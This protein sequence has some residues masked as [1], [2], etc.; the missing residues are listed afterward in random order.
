M[1][2]LADHGLT[3]ISRSSAMQYRK[4][5]KPLRQIARELGVQGA[6]EGTVRRAGD[7]V[8][9]SAQLVDARSERPL[10]GR[11]YQRD[12]ADVL[13]MQ[14][15]VALTIVGQ[16]RLSLT[17]DVKARL[18]TPR[19]INPEAH[20]AYL[21]GRSNVSQYTRESF[22]RALEYFQRAIEIDPTYAEAYAGLS[23]T[24][25]SLSSAWL[26]AAEAMP[27]ARAAAAKALELDPQL[28]SA[29]ASLATVEAFYDWQWG[30]AEREFSRA[31]EL[32]PSEPTAHQN[33]G[34]L[35]V[36]HRR[37]EEA[38]RELQRAHE[39]DPLSPFISFYGLFPANL[40]RNYA[41]AIA[42]G[43]KVAAEYPTFSFPHLILGQAY[44]F[45]G[46]RG[47]AM[48]E[49]DRAYE[50]ESNPCF[51]AWKAY[52]L[53]A[54]GDRRPARQLLGR[55]QAMTETTYV[56]P[57][58][59]AIVHAGL[60]EKDLAFRW[61]DKAAEERAE[62]LHFLQVDPALDSLRDDPRFARLL[63]QV[64]FAP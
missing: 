39:I 51:L 58:F 16:I 13:S 26:P 18:T 11:S 56:Q 25:Y 8:R 31:I 55:L 19:K 36:I 35:L 40:G 2:I 14:S 6:V 64:G 60:G 17:P 42:Q 30:D 59:F 1:C 61:L 22:T 28:A 24:Y 15:D 41:R 49:V 5:K 29:H 50:L 3:V 32:N 10:W 7:Q 46:D 43:R 33:Y 27:R 63:R 34:N 4:S 45:S 57:Y 23:N 48:E 9:I 12:L 54:S 53:A 21:R 38:E 20:E 47:R 62:E 44:F 37:F 52:M